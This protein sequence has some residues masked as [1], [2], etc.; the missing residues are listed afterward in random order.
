MEENKTTEVT[1]TFEDHVKKSIETKDKVVQLTKTDVA[2]KSDFKLF[3]FNGDNSKV[4]ISNWLSLF[5]NLAKRSNW[6][7]E[8]MQ[9]N[10]ANYLDEDAFDFYIEHVLSKDSNWNEAKK[11]MLER[12]DQYEIEPFV[13]FLSVKWTPQIE[14]KEYFKKMRALGIASGL[15][16]EDIVNGLTRGVPAH[17]RN[18]LLVVKTLQQWANVA[19]LLQQ[20]FTDHN[21]KRNGNW[22][23]RGNQHRNRNP[24]KPRMNHSLNLPNDH[25]MMNQIHHNS[26]NDA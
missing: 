5:E 11:A 6:S 8:E 10:L 1:S 22:K 21:S 23:S 13:E 3:S 20:R 17:L 14:L 7:E 26:N 4:K 18:E 2:A 15:K 16:E 25:P 9:W 24:N 12:F 19:H